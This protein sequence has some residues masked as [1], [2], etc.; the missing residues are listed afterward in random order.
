MK[1]G[2]LIRA[3]CMLCAV[4]P[5]RGACTVRANTRIT[6]VLL[7]RSL[8]NGWFVAPGITFI[9]HDGSRWHA[10]SGLLHG[11]AEVVRRLNQ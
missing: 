6:P 3:S 8:G 7:E 5:F 2:F 4:V 10:Q 9:V 1:W 11:G